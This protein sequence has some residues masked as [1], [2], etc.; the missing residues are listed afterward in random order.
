MITATVRRPVWIFLAAWLPIALITR[1]AATDDHEFSRLGTVES[2]VERHSYWL[3][4]SK[5]HGSGDKIFYDG[6]FYSHQPPLLATL[7]SPVFWVLSKAGLHFWNTAPFDL[8]YYLFTACTNGVALA[9]IIVVFEIVLRRLGVPPGRSVACAFLLILGSWLL[10]YGLVTNN[11]EAAAL[12]VAVL[13][14]LLID[15]E[16]GRVDAA[17][18]ALV[19]LTLGLLVA[20]EVVPVVSFLPLTIVYLFSKPQLRTRTTALPW[21][22]G[23]AV[24]LVLHAIINIKQTGDLLP[25]GFH[26]ELFAYEGSKF[27]ES[28]LTGNLNH[29]TVG[30][31]LHYS[32]QALF[33][34]KGFFTYSPILLLGCLAGLMGSILWR[35]GRAVL[36]VMTG[37]WFL[38]LTASLLMTNNFGGFASGFRHATYL[39]P[40]MLIGLAPVFAGRQRIVSAIVLAVAALSIVVLFIVTVPRPWYPYAVPPKPPIVRP[41]DGYLPVVAQTVRRFKGE[42]DQFGKPVVA[43]P[44]AAAR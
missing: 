23:L 36:L 6:H 10:P 40:A 19:G 2:L 16:Q 30:E 26:T 13:A 42:V 1:T 27:N 31:F 33:S 41:W 37:S 39:A 11:H 22:I 9:L 21:V 32:W 12:L 15:L 4:E 43:A 38:S 14:L 28:T 29:P 20:V 18:C 34:E 3:E 7:Q 44:A 24:P 8:A 35:R 17:R 25:G 5:F